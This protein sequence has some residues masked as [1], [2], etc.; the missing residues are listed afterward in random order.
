MTDTDLLVTAAIAGA[1][2]PVVLAGVYLLAVDA[3][4]RY[5]DE[6]LR[7]AKT[8]LRQYARDQS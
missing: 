6:Q 5:V 4:K 8:E 1:A 2:V 3:A 7:E